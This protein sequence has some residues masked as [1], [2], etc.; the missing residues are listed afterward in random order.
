MLGQWSLL[1]NTLVGGKS[2][3]VGTVEFAEQHMGG[4]VIGYVHVGMTAV[5]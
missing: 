1:N 4:W 2:M 5:C 3:N